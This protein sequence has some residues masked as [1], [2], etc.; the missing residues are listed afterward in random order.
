MLLKETNLL[1]FYNNQWIL[2]LRFRDKGDK[3]RLLSTRIEAAINK[4]SLV[5]LLAR[6]F[7]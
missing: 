5:K 4:K 6:D 7:L 3:I 1:S 2:D